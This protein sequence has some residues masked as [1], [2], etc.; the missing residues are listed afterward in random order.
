MR[1]LTKKLFDAIMLDLWPEGNATVVDFGIDSQAHYEALYGPIREGE[2]TIEQLDA[3]IC[4]GAKLTALVK[5]CSSNP[6]KGIVFRT[7]WD[8]LGPEEDAAMAAA[9]GLSDAADCM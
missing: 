8:D 2:I 5:D 4:D 6:H 1:P 3:A 7:A 9:V